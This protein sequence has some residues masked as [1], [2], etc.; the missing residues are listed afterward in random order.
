MT[1]EGVSLKTLRGI[2]IRPIYG[3]CLLPQLNMFIPDFTMEA[4]ASFA[5]LSGSSAVPLRER[6]RPNNNRKKEKTKDVQLEIS[7]FQIQGLRVREL[8]KGKGLVRD[9]SF[10]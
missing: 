1:N 9:L 6:F 2:S 4:G 3:I 8:R 10:L 7:H 5:S